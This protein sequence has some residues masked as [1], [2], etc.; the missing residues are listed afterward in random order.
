MASKGQQQKVGKRQLK[1]FG[2]KVSSP[3]LWQVTARE[4]ILAANHLLDWYV[5]PRLESDPKDLRWTI[6]ECCQ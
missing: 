3:Q 5:P 6:W 2:V 1:R 4:F